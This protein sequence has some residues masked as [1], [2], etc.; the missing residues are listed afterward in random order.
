M[1]NLCEVLEVF[2]RYTLALFKGCSYCTNRVRFTPPFPKI[3][4]PICLE[5]QTKFVKIAFKNSENS[6][7]SKIAFIF[8]HSF[9]FPLLPSHQHKEYR[10]PKPTPNTCQTCMIRL[11]PTFTDRYFTQRIAQFY[12]QYSHQRRPKRNLPEKRP[13]VRSPE[14]KPA[15]TRKNIS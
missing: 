6:K 8:L 11:P 15:S 4:S 14:P 10:I 2:F 3:P 13:T 5:V 7:I 1:E 12:R 9:S